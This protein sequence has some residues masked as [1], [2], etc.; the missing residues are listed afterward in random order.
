MVERR[1]KLDF[2]KIMETPPKKRGSAT[3]IYPHF[4]VGPSKDLM[5]RGR[6]FYAVWDEASGLWS[7]DELDV[8]RLVDDDLRRYLEDRKDHEESEQSY[9]V[10]YMSDYS[11]RSWATFKKYIADMPD[12]YHRL[13]E[14][15][16]FQNT[17][18]SKKDYVSHKLPYSLGEGDISAYD[19]LIGTLYDEDERAKIEWAIGAVV[20]GD[21]KDIQKFLVLYGE[22][23]AGKSTILNIIEQLFEGY[24]VSFDAK[25]LTSS[26]NSFSMEVFKNNP[27]VAIQH[28]G[29]LSRIEDNTR[30]NSIVSHEHMVMNE[31]YKS[32][33][34]IKLNSFLFMATNRPVKI[35]DSKSGIIR[36]LIDV[37]PSG[38]KVPFKKYQSLM[39]K[40]SFELGAIAQHCLDVYNEMGKSYYSNYRPMSMMFKT[41]VFFNYVENYLDIFTS[42]DG[43]TLKQAYSMYKDY[44]TE[45]LLDNKL[46][47]YK[48]REELKS[49]FDNFDASVMVDGQRMRSYYS[50]FKSSK[51]LIGGKSDQRSESD[52]SNDSEEQSDIWLHM[53]CNESLLD[54]IL[55]DCPAQYANSDEK[56]SYKWDNVKKKLKDL[57]TKKLHYVKPPEDIIVIDFD[58]RDETGEK[59]A[60]LN[61]EA[62]SKWPPTYAEFSKGGSGVH[63]HYRFRGSVSRLETLYEPGVEIKTFS[64]GSSLRRRLSACNDIPVAVLNGGLPLKEEKVIDFKAVSNE[65]ALRTLIDRNLKKE[66]HPGT[67]PSIDFIK[68]ILD[69]AYKSGLKYDVSDMRQDIFVFASGSTHHSSECMRSVG[70]M[71]FVS[72]T[73]PEDIPFGEED[74]IVFFDVEVFPNLML[75]NW[76]YAGDDKQCVRMIN[77]EPESIER[78]FKFK[79]IGFNNR[80]YDNHILYARYLGYSVTEIYELSKNIVSGEKAFFRDAYNISYTDVYDFCS[81]KQSLKKWEIELGIHHQE[82]G[83]PWDEP[84]PEDQWDLVAEYCDNDVIATEC[85]FNE[86]YSDFEAR[87][88]LVE[89]AN[90]LMG[91]G[92][93]VNDT[94]NTL[95][96]KLIVGNDKEPWKEF[97]YP[98]LAKEFPGYE[99]NQMG[100]D[101]SRYI[102][103][104]VIISGKSIYKGY[105]PGEG[106]FVYACPGMYND[107]ESDDSASHHPSSIIAENG[108]GKYTDNFKRLKDIRIMIKHKQFEELS[109]M[110]DGVLS[111]YLDDPAKAKALSYA[112]KIAINSVYGLTAAK[113]QNKLKD[114]RNVDNWVAKR[115]ALFMIDL[116]LEVQAR[117]YKVIHVKTDSIKIENPDDDIRKFIYEYGQ[118]FGYTF[119]VE[120]IFDRLCLVNKAVYICRYSDDDP[121]EPGKWSATG[122]QFAQPYVF[123]TLFSRED[124]VFEDMCEMKTVT[125][126]M[127]LDMN[128]DLP[129]DE[130]FYKFVGRAGQFCPIKKGCGGGELMR[131]GDN[132]K[133]SYVTGTKGYR[134]LESEQVKLLGKEDD[135]DRSYYNDLVD[136]AVK[137]ISEFGDFEMFVD[138]YDIPF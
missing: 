107:A 3:E 21:S 4:K 24:C 19:E 86:R 74:P 105:D 123:K 56:P 90:A 98:D 125:T 57:D 94:T 60:K 10:K 103:E 104:D 42:Q 79:L 50:G 6:A 15:L 53:D 49:Y 29:D 96:T 62:A 54:D 135:I 71:K 76:K 33:Y 89:L 92:N 111:R 88:I 112:L 110:Y 64:G 68:K 14:R 93:T 66:I 26:G 55:A 82:L 121:E 43:V 11:S 22:A 129:E 100:I 132:D 5:I 102:S 67:K 134:W 65:K 25:A 30:I 34:R 133:Y 69:D 59:N 84:V 38:R 83:L 51:F 116:M 61:I 126:S 78:L 35:T 18:V 45:T 47:M 81:K 13:D 37:T 48:F 9:S 117:G 114:P 128:E 119:E 99:F 137:D 95:T 17:E 41:D 131:K 77:P 136:K 113:F 122:D 72:D 85:V 52:I 1:L 70:E 32:G 106:G 127:Y 63:L 91:D 16:T 20:S 7:T 115:G 80:K 120:H 58:I 12:H 23:G 97:V 101:K 44:C 118:K 36:R 75:V 31:K 28:D 8:Q 39:G 73:E 2:Y 124:I 27:L 108:F 40:I 87:E 46:P 109:K 138:D 130:H